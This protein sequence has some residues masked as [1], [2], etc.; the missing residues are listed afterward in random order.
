MRSSEPGSRTTNLSFGERPV[1]RPVSTTSGPPSASRPSPRVECVRVELRGG[2]VPE[3]VPPG[4]IPCRSSPV[5]VVVAVI[6]E[7]LPRRCAP[8]R[9]SAAPKSCVGNGS[10][11]PADMAR[12]LARGR[13]DAATQRTP[14]RRLA[15][16]RDDGLDV[17]VPG[18]EGGVATAQP[19]QLVVR[20]RARRSRP[21][22][23]TTIWSASRTVESR[24]AIA[25][26]VRPSARRS[27]AACTARS[28]WV[29]S[30]EVASS[31]TRIGG[32]RR[33]VRAIAMRCFSPPENR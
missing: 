17:R 15:R 12:A 4:T 25:I 5:S 32:L 6:V 29:S 20:A 10:R 13:P 11:K 14:G 1:K 26:T 18:D 23:R 16:A 27:S 28:V 7:G 19:E 31:S 33:I 24:W 21:W 8:W 9:G 3:H 22:S 30:A 2:R